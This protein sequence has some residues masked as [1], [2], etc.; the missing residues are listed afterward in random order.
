M[1]NTLWV[2]VAAF[3]VFFMNAGFALVD[4]TGTSS[5]VRDSFHRLHLASVAVA[6]F[7]GRLARTLDGSARSS[8]CTFFAAAA[9]RASDIRIACH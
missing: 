4:S 8:V 2:L 9:T 5:Y 3:L 1:L 6:A 7:V